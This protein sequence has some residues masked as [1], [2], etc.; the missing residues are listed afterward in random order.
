VTQRGKVLLA[1][2]RFC[3][4]LEEA[5]AEAGLQGLRLVAEWIKQPTCLEADYLTLIKAIS[6]SQAP[7]SVW[8]GVIVEIRA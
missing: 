4:S 6:A 3:G 1:A 7:R 8:A 2:W 5:E